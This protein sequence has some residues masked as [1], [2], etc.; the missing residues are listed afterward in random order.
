MYGKGTCDMLRDQIARLEKKTESQASTIEWLRK[1][2]DQLEGRVDQLEQTVAEMMTVEPELALS[3]F[4]DL[5]TDDLNQQIAELTDQLEV[6]RR[7]RETMTALI[8]SRLAGRFG[9]PETRPS[10]GPGSVPEK[11]GVIFRS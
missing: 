11:A 1:K 5:Q 6:E 2:K 3:G 7:A 9:D 8:N 4:L 10:F